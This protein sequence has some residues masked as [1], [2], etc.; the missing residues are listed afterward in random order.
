MSPIIEDVYRFVLV[1]DPTGMYPKEHWFFRMAWNETL[2]DGFW[3]SGSVWKAEVNHGPNFYVI[4]RGEEL[5]P[6]TA[7]QY[8]GRVKRL[9]MGD[10]PSDQGPSFYGDADVF[11][12]RRARPSGRASDSFSG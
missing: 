5:Q 10:D 7:V 12:S 11:T 2:A 3:P 1:H 4:V 6:Q 8:K 9:G